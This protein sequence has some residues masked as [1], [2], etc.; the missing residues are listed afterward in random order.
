MVIDE[1]TIRQQEVTMERGYT[2]DTM[3][4]K[5]TLKTS[6]KEQER[7]ER[8]KNRFESHK[9]RVLDSCGFCLSNKRIWAQ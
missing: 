3:I 1:D 5:K 7:Q 4:D 2:R 8:Q 9:A 6:R